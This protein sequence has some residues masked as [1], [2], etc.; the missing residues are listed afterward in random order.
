M[1]GRDPAGHQPGLGPVYTLCQLVLLCAPSR[2]D[3][4]YDL[5]CFF[6]QGYCPYVVINH[7]DAMDRR[8]QRNEPV[9]L[10]CNDRF[11]HGKRRDSKT[12]M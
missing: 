12:A 6:A 1:K 8:G 9:Y 4:R 5:Y 11:G 10:S 3:P 2:K 7:G